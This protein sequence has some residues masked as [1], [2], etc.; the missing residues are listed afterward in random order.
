V[1]HLRIKTGAG[2]GK[3]FEIK[4]EVITVGRDE[5]QTIQ[6][7]DQGVSRQHAEIFRLGKMLFVRDLNSTNGT[8]VNNEKVSEEALKKGD[9]ILIGTTILTVEGNGEAVRRSIAV[10]EEF[11]ERDKSIAS[12]TVELKVNIPR[13]GG[14]VEPAKQVESRNLSVI[15]EVAAIL[16]DVQDIEEALEPMVEVLAKAVTADTAYLFTLDAPGGKIVRRCSFNPQG[17][18]EEKI[19]RTIVKRVMTTGLPVLTTD[20]ALDDRFRL[21]E[22]IVLKRIQ[23]VLCAP[24]LLGGRVWGLLYF[25]GRKFGET[26]EVVDLELVSAVAVQVT[27]ALTSI[28][29]GEKLRQ[30]L[31]GT[32]EALVTAMEIVDP[33]GEGHAQRVAL[34][35]VAVARQLGL[36][37]KQ[38]EGIRLAALLHDVGKLAAHH[39]V[40]GVPRE[41]LQEQ[42]VLAGEK[43]LMKIDGL[44]EI[45]PGVRHHHERADGSGFPGGLMNDALPLMARI[46]I[47]TNAFDNECARGGIGEQGMPVRDALKAFEKQAGKEFDEEVVRALLICHADGKLYTQGETR[48]R[49]KAAR[50]PARKSKK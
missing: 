11:V 42:H 44:R 5:S 46:I 49:K 26:F 32:I 29:A 34:Y 14:Q 19:S 9:E 41:K 39:S 6:V 3:I 2:K 8:Y 48:V 22:S 33:A 27:A 47:V 50:P 31:I 43:I 4:N 28:D 20:A 10:P 36:P 35:S 45:L 40:H 16:R 24:I 13:A 17:L 12:T 25:H 18:V 15:Y 21:S 23:S 1:P 38:V 30:S 37:A 7:L